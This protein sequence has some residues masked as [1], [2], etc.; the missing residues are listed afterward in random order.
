MQSNSR[1]WLIILL[2]VFFGGLVFVF[3]LLSNW[4]CKLLLAFILFSLQ[5]L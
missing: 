4:L 3:F 1:N 2:M 5:L